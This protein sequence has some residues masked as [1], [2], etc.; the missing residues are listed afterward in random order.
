MLIALTFSVI[1]SSCAPSCFEA[2]MLECARPLLLK[3]D[4][5]DPVL[6]PYKLQMKYGVTAI[7][8]LTKA[9]TTG[10]TTAVE[11]FLAAMMQE[12]GPTGTYPALAVINDCYT[13]MFR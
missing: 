12:S 7:S 10:G 9:Y 6:G 8:H 1:A 2:K 5:G 3:A 13:L 11:G 4:A